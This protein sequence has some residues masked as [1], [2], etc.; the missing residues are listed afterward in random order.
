MDKQTTD[1]IIT[2][3]LPKLYGFAVKKTF[4]YSEA[5]ELCAEIVYQV[6]LSLL[7][8]PEVVNLDGY[9]WR[10]STHTYARYVSS[11]KRQEGMSLNETDIPYYEDFLPEDSEEDFMRL[12]R[13]VA[14]LSKKRRKIVYLFYYKG[15]SISAIAKNLEI[16][17]GTVKW[18]LNKARNELKEGFSMER[19]IGK[20]GLSPITAQ[21]YGHSGQPGSHGGP[22]Y[23]LQ[24]ALNLN[25]VYSVYHTPRTREEIAE[26]LGITPV[27]L[28]EKIDLLEEN[29]FLIKTGGNRYT[30]YVKFTPETYSLEAKESRIKL[31]MEAAAMLAQEYVPLVREAI[32]A[33][34]DVYIPGGNRE[35]LEA[36]AIFYAVSNKCSIPVQTDLSRYWLK[37]TDGGNYSA[38]VDLKA[39][40]SDPDYRPVLEIWNYGA[41]GCMYRSSDKYPAVLSWSVDS[42]YCSRVGGWQN[43]LLTDYEYLYEY[44]TGTIRE[45]TVNREKFK[46]LRERA[47]LTGDGKVAIMVVRGKADDFWAKIP[48]LAESQRDKYAVIALELAQAEAKNYPPQMQDLIIAR[49]VG[50]FFG[51]VTALM[52]LDILYGDGTLR[53]LTDQ[54][55]VT[56]QLILFS[57]VLP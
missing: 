2:E 34:Q 52:V 15:I 21:N 31:Q 6:Y 47:Y 42:R 26:E 35:L 5:E 56:S 57:D 39:E 4:L 13:E 18:H 1:R 33:V 25:I 48:S 49:Q 12:R 27:F 19:K 7:K 9:I 32:S 51:N 10:I 24:D 23:Y 50:G 41:C 14:F 16:P 37:T 43:N 29:G 45:D 44:M 55:K 53:P 22:E 38:H 28:E 30:T 54:E 36:A 8:A 20:L 11:R 17:E 3:Y 40:Q 46:R